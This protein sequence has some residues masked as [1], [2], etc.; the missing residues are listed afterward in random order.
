MQN[1]NGYKLIIGDK[2][3][4]Y[5]TYTDS[6]INAPPPPKNF[7]QD[8]LVASLHLDHEDVDN[9]VNVPCCQQGRCVHTSSSLLP[10]IYGVKYD[11]LSN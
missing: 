5:H 9:L 7:V 4:Y 11:G 10:D 2:H 1:V 8:P 6:Q 3:T